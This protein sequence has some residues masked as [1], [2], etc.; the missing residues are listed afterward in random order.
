[1]HPIAAFPSGW[2]IDKLGM[3]IG[4]CI[5]GTAVIA[6]TW[7]RYTL[8]VGSPWFCLIGSALSAFG[9]VFVLNSSSLMA[10]N[11][12]PNYIVPKIIMICVLVN[13]LSATIGASSAGWF[14]SNSSTV[15]DVRNFL[16][17]EA[18]LITVPFVIFMIFFRE[19]P[20][21][22]PSHS[23]ELLVPT[24]RNNYKESL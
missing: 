2:V 4:C 22:P 12:F 18:I 10:V 24:A 15:D 3:K 1:M 14:I 16:R 13:F 9:N 8:N 19:R 11:W 6:G 7:L 17:S 5:G 21:V 23:A 20:K